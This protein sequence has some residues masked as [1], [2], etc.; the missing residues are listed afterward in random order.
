MKPPRRYTT[1][2]QILAAIDKTHQA[3]IDL[4]TQ[5]EAIEGQIK[6]LQLEGVTFNMNGSTIDDLRFESKKLRQQAEYQ[7][8]K[9]AKKLGLRLSEFRTMLL[10]IPDMGGEDGV[11]MKL[12]GLLKS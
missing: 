6:A 5:A 11:P 7:I 4:L 10:P 12:G 3:A 2:E 9:R 8:E 1:E